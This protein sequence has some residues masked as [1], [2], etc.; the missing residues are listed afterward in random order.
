MYSPG[1]YHLMVPRK[2]RENL[3]FRKRILLECQRNEDYRDAVLEMCRNDILFFVDVF[4]WQFNPNFIGSGSPQIGPFV[5]WDYQEEAIRTVLQCVWDRSDLVI[6]KSREMGASW[7]CLIIMLWFF[8]FHPYSTFLCISRN[9]DAVDNGTSDC[10]FWKLEYMLKHIPDWMTPKISKR[11]MSYINEDNGSQITGQAT[12]GK[13]GVGGRATAIF[14][15]EFGLIDE[16]WELLDYT[17]NTSGCRIFNSTHRG[18]KTAFYDLTVKA[19][20]SDTCRKLVMHWSQH[21]DKRL[22]A[23]HWDRETQRVVYQDPHYK[24][25]RTFAPVTDGTPTGGPCPGLRSPWYDKKVKSMGS[26]RGVAADLDINPSGSLELVFDPLMVHNLK[27]SFCRDG[28]R[29]DLSYDRETAEPVRMFSEDTG[30]CI[31]WCRL[32]ADGKP[33]PGRYVFGADIAQGNGSATSSCLSG[34]NLETGEK[35]LEY[36][37]PAIEPKE[38]A[39]LA[40]ALCR[41]F[42][43]HGSGDGMFGSSAGQPAKL[44]WENGGPGNTFRKHVMELRHPDV[45]LKTTDH[46]LKKD[47][48]DLP[49]WNNSPD[50]M[51]NLI[52]GYRDALRA[53]RFLNRSTYALSECLAFIYSPEGN[54]YHT[55]WKDPKDKSAARVNHG[56]RVV[57]DAL[58]WKMCEEMKL[59]ISIADVTGTPVV[60]LTHQVGGLAWRAEIGKMAARVDDWAG[61]E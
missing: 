21:P 15:D 46:R 31:L 58:C 12:T 39:Y 61:S 27:V 11:K 18:T 53:K 6:E 13:S 1:Q 33:P 42:K 20:T 52:L 37:D 40:V 50:S 44:I 3:L 22:G 57:A 25:Y 35:V 17:A 4:I 24:Y 48:S 56:D 55:G 30:K 2:R 47:I 51:M 32:D 26:S 29:A 14:I 10:L 34:V 41:L 5:A 45:Y 19:T 43:R 59:L 38:F 49:G 16:D 54:I 9:A 7:L 8:F 28:T 60:P 36:A 23:Y